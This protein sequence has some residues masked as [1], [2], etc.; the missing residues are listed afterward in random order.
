MDF[1]VNN[2]PFAGR[3]GKYVTS[4][5]LKD[6]LYRELERNVA[7]RVDE[8]DSPDTHTVSGRGEL[9]L[10]ILMETMRREGYEFQVSKPEVILREENGQKLEPYEQVEIEVAQDA[11]GVV[12]EMMGQ[13]RGTLMDMKYRDDGSVHYVHKVPTRGL[14]GFPGEL[15]GVG[16][17]VRG[18][19]VA[20]ARGGRDGCSR[21]RR[22][23]GWKCPFS[24]ALPRAVRRLSACFENELGDWRWWHSSTTSR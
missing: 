6:R 5:Q 13:R 9:H 20:A 3:E 11:A 17:V 18:R 7:L 21:L 24:C 2:S 8:T 1:I 14:L 19:L 15:G 23:R 10:G 12:V 16:R 4:R 22:L